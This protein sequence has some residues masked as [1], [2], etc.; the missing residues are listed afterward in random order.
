MGGR[1]NSFLEIKQSRI[2]G[3]QKNTENKHHSRS[4]FLLSGLSANGAAMDSPARGQRLDNHRC[5]SADSR[6]QITQEYGRKREFF[7]S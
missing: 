7:F 3:R 2:R 4:P 5:H 1:E 6:P